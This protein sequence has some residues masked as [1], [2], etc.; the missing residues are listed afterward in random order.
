MRAS[1]YA[2]SV[3][4]G[5]LFRRLVP[6]QQ[7]AVRHT[8][9]PRPQPRNELCINSW[10]AARPRP[11]DGKLV[12]VVEEA[13]FYAT[14]C[15]AEGERLLLAL[16]LPFPTSRPPAKVPRLYIFDGMTRPGCAH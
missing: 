6:Q 11:D 12:A 10:V 3:I 5:V 13:E 9:P 1:L 2:G 15:R 7:D 14:A 4:S 8:I 16:V